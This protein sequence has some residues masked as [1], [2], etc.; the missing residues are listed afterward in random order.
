[1]QHG[2]LHIEIAMRIG[3]NQQDAHAI[4]YNTQEGQPDYPI[5]ADR[6]RAKKSANGLINNDQGNNHERY[7]INEGGNDF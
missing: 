4:E 1:M 2:W 3:F 7:G 5:A 6:F